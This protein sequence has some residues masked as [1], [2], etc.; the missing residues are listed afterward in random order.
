MYKAEASLFLS[1]SNNIN[2]AKTLINECKRLITQAE[3]PD[4]SD[5][6]N[7]KDAI[8]TL[9]IAGLVTLVEERKK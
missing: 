7:C 4:N 8:N 1:A 2:Y 6:S 3:L 9:D 5:Y